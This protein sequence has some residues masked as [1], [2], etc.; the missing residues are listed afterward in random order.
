MARNRG[1]YVESEIRASLDEIW[2]RTQNPAL[3]ELWDLRFTKI[4]Y[5]TRGSE[6]P[7][8]FLYSTRIGFGLKIDGQGES[9]GTRVDADGPRTSALKFW[10]ADPKSLIETGSG[11][12]KY[13][14]TS[15][16]VKFLTWY[17]YQT[18]FG[19]TGR[20]IDLLVFRPLI[21]WA[22]AWSFDR[23]RLWVESG[24]LPRFSM[25]MALI[26]AVARWGIAFIWLWQGLVPKLLFAN[27]DE[28]TMLLAGGLS[29]EFLPAIG[30]LEVTIAVATLGLWRWRPFFLWNGLA[31]V[32]AV[33]AVALNSPSYLVGAFNPVTLNAGVMLLSI[34]GYLSAAEIP[35]ASRCVR[36]A[37]KDL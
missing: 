34:V 26:H 3:H 27:T 12:W 36:Q 11:Y 31:M 9:T 29:P 8:R 23:L 33:I 37:P 4:D 17:D 20:L 5:L 6:E 16:G 35:S 21:S 24:A 18:R 1:I 7:Q 2:L 15:N 25:R 30:A 19:A 13:V 14:P 32:A 28:Q 10:S 22:T